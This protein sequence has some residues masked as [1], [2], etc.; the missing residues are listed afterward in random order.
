MSITD[1]LRTNAHSERLQKSTF[2]VEKQ[3]K[4]NQ[5]VEFCSFSL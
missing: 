5:H 2:L 4:K 1:G 3:N